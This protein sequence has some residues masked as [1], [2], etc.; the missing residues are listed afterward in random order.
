MA[1]LTSCDHSL[2]LVHD[3]S[4]WC[5]GTG[6]IAM[7]ISKAG[8]NLQVHFIKFISYQKYSAMNGACSTSR[9]HV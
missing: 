6:H 1:F 9:R 5:T 2:E 7:C 4:R 8:P 3:F